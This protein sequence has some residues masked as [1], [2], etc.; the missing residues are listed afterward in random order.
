ASYGYVVAIQ[1]IRGRLASDG[2]FVPLFSD[3]RRDDE[4]GF[5]TV[6]WASTLPGSTGRVGVLGTSYIAA[7]AWELAPLRPPALG[8]MCVHGM[9]GDSRDL[10]PGVVRLSMSL[11]W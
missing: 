7:M 6:Q 5:D 8:A 10:R 2:D 11:P 3:G 4:D 9:V 1:D